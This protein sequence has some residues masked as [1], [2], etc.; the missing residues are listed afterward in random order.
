MNPQHN[1]HG[2]LERVEFLWREVARTPRQSK[3]YDELADEIRTEGLAYLAGVRRRPKGPSQGAR[4]LTIGRLTRPKSTWSGGN[5]PEEGEQF[6]LVGFDQLR[7]SRLLRS[8]NR[9][10]E[11]GR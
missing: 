8:T 10:L 1:V 6:P 9:H 4:R 2:H 5:P 11:G 3:R 7:L